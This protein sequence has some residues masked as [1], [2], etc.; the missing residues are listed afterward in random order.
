MVSCSQV[1]AGALRLY[2]EMKKISS[3]RLR[4]I[5]HDA[6]ARVLRVEL[7]DGSMLQHSAVGEEA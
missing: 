3:G 4:A 2:L 6:R 7:D 1:L 5:G